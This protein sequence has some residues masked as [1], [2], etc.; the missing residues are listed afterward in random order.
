MVKKKVHVIS[1]TETL[2]ARN[3]LVISAEVDMDDVLI[4]P[5]KCSLPGWNGP[6][7]KQNV[8]GGGGGAPTKN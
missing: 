5:C 6:Q 4:I 3:L 7:V 1:V 2:Q 8:R